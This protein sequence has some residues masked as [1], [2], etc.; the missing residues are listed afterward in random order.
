MRH[1]LLDDDGLLWIVDWNWAGFYTTWFEHFGMRLAARKNL[2]PS[3]WKTAINFVIDGMERWKE[4]HVVVSKVAMDMMS[5]VS[6][7]LLDL[8]PC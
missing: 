6:S 8:S 5:T 4:L 3:S 2:E 7:S 1:I